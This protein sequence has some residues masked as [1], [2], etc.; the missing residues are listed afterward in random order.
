M[1][2]VVLV[3]SKTKQLLTANGQGHSKYDSSI[4]TNIT[5]VSIQ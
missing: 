1:Y 2:A 4:S 5:I 3:K